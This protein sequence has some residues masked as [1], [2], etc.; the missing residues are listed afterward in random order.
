MRR[1]SSSKQLLMGRRWRNS[2]GPRDIVENFGPTT[3]FGVG[4]DVLNCLTL[5]NG[6]A[7]STMS[8][9]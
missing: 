6:S 5:P 9:I 3:R 8:R 4:L 7:V 1:R 2:F